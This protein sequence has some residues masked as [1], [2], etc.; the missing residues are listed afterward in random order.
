MIP[1]FLPE[2]SFDNTT[3]FILVISFG[4][5]VERRAAFRSPLPRNYRSRV[6]LHGFEFDALCPLS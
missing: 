3:H 4:I 5:D 6:R 1:L 2:I